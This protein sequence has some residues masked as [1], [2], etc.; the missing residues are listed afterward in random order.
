MEHE[1]TFLGGLSSDDDN[2]IS[3]E[4][5]DLSITM[6]KFPITMYN[7]RLYDLE[8]DE[9]YKNEIHHDIDNYE[10]INGE[11]EVEII[12]SSSQG[13]NLQVVDLI[14][15][16]INEMKKIK[17]RIIRIV[18]KMSKLYRKL[19]SLVYDKTPIENILQSISI[20]I[21]NVY[22]IIDKFIDINRKGC[23]MFAERLVD[24]D[25]YSLYN[26]Y[27]SYEIIVEST[28]IIEKNVSILDKRH[29]ELY[30]VGVRLADMS[31]VMM[32]ACLL[33]KNKIEGF[34]IKYKK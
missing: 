24:F 9:E 19:N 25:R 20:I 22:V 16:D 4:D 6:D 11:M 17:E 8:H 12:D 23:W 3:L 27:D 29:K 7:N 10:D 1:L 5:Y 14:N 2:F 30:M 32:N 18:E 34:I 33:A 28:S 13:N 15:K 26:I 21:S 31:D